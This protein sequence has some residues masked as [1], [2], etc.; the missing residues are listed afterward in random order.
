MT[1]SLALVPA[2]GLA[3]ELAID[4]AAQQGGH[5]EPLALGRPPQGAMLLLAEVDLRP[6]HGMMLV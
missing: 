5:A 2:L 4:D 3:K 1:A 6:N